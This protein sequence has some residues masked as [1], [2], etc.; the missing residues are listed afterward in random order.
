M[1][2]CVFVEAGGGTGESTRRRHV[3]KPAIC[4]GLPA[5]IVFESHTSIR[6]SPGSK[7]FTLSPGAVLY[8]V[9]TMGLPTSAGLRPRST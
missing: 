4:D 1:C 6:L 9:T 2:M 3:S 5:M 8:C 7:V